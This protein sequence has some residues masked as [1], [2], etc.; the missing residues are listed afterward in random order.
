M[1]APVGCVLA[2]RYWLINEPECLPSG[3]HWSLA[4]SSAN[5]YRRQ[6]RRQPHLLL[7]RERIGPAHTRTRRIT[8]AIEHSNLDRF[9]KMPRYVSNFPSLSSDLRIA[10]SNLFYEPIRQ[11]R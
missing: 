4:T 7:M 5:P 10:A 3:P 11:S 2:H 9:N 1:E 8:N 6:V